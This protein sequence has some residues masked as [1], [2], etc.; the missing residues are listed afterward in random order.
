M[1]LTSFIVSAFILTVIS[2][3]YTKAIFNTLRSKFT[4]PIIYYLRQ[5]RRR[6]PIAL[7]V[8]IFDMTSIIASLV[9]FVI[10]KDNFYIKSLV[11]LILNTLSLLLGIVIRPW[12]IILFNVFAHLS[13]ILY[14]F[15]V[16]VFF[17]DNLELEYEFLQ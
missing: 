11:V 15:V 5:G 2:L 4:E 13:E 9:I 14:T 10:F 8:D 17:I 12:G 3:V 1:E 16:V 6:K 7:L